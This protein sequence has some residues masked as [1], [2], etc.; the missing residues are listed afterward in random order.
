[1]PETPSSA[2]S[3]IVDEGRLLARVRHTNVVTIYGADRFGDSVGLWMEFIKGKTLKQLLSEQGAFGARE[4]SLI[5]I[6]LC[7]ALAAVH[8]AGLLHRDIKAQNVMR[9]DG[10]RIVLMDFGAGR[11]LVQSETEAQPLTGTPLY[12]A[13]EVLDSHPASASSEVYS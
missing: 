1:N 11:E 5:G 4:A 2:M 8:Q 7:A 12:M 6:D 10:G 3:A 13:P 9:E